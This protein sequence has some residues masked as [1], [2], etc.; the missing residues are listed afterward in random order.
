MLFLSMMTA[1]KPSWHLGETAQ[2]SVEHAPNGT[3][4]PTSDTSRRARAA[5]FD[6]I[7]GHFNSPISKAFLISKEYHRTIFCQ[8]FFRLNRL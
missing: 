2:V 4:C 3:H 8:Y 7:I 1:W 5:S 6:N